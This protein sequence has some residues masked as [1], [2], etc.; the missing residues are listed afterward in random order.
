M[1]FSLQSAF[2]YETK[3]R[4]M[5]PNTRL[6]QQNIPQNALQYPLGDRLPDWGRCIEVVPGVLWIRMALPFALNHINLWLLR[7][8]QDTPNGRRPGWTVVDC[9]IHKEESI[10]QW[11]SIFAHELQGLPILRVIVTHMHPDHVGLAHWLCTRWDAPLYM[12]GTDYQVAC[13][14]STSPTTF[15]GDGGADFFA[16]H[17]L[18]NPELLTQIRARTRYFVSMVP[19]MPRRYHRLLDGMTLQIGGHPWRC[20]SG[21]GHAPEHMALYCED[22]QILIGGDMMLPTIS[23]N[24]SVYEQEPE[25]NS[26]ALFLNSIDKFRPLPVQTLT[27]PAH[28][29]PFTGLHQRIEQLHAHHQDRLRDVLQACQQQP[30]SASDLL[31]VLFS[32]T[33]DAHQTTFAMGESIAHLHYL[34]FDGQLERIHDTNGIIRFRMP[35]LVSPSNGAPPPV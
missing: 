29:R 18:K 12:S 20:I 27:L 7:D 31:P 21:Y 25:A 33:L 15:A 30:C 16:S 8:E 26:L 28:G 4:S 35:A 3:A 32:R 19:A 6:A 11:E 23:T 24:V 14:G 13:A 2:D 17:G 22:L 1:A 10:A 34:W 5:N 9:C